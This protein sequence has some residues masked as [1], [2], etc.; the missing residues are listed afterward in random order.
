MRPLNLLPSNFSRLPPGNQVT[1]R[2]HRKRLR[3]RQESFTRSLP[4]WRM[5]SYDRFPPVS[6]VLHSR[7]GPWELR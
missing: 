6:K 7:E 2:G 3:K 4:A 5:K 1:P